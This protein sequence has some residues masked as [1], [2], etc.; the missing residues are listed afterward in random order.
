ME[1]ILARPKKCRQISSN[2]DYMMFKPDGIPL[3]E[4]EHN[5]LGF[6]ELEALRLSDF[7]GMKHEDAAKIMAIS[8]AT[9]GR[10]LEKARFTLIEAILNKKSIVI[11]QG[12]NCFADNLMNNPEVIEKF[13]EEKK[14]KCQKCPK[15]IQYL[16]SIEQK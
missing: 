2:P 13:V 4:T 14:E 5:I 1:I 6:D 16:N 7:E 11:T 9:F 3:S 10:T 8:R 12:N 15:L